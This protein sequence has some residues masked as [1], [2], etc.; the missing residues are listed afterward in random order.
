MAEWVCNLICDAM[1]N[2]SSFIY[3][4]IYQFI[5]LFVIQAHGT[6]EEKVTKLLIILPRRGP[7]AFTQFRN[8]LR[9]D[10]DWLAESLDNALQTQTKKQADEQTHRNLVKV[11]NRQLVPLVLSGNFKYADDRDPMSQTITKVGYL[12]TMLEQKVYKALNYPQTPRKTMS[13]EKMIETKLN[14]DRSVETLTS[15]I[16]E[17]KKKLKAEEKSKREVENLK[18]TVETMKKKEKNQQK[19]TKKYISDNSALKKR[20]E[21]LLKEKEGLDIENQRLKS[22][23][24]TLKSGCEIQEMF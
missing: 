3:L 12:T 11:I 8:L 21:K 13:I 14:E 23:L 10:Y 16:L 20:Y 22:E 19:M 5:Y 1:L 9:S 17:L 4:F 15:E 7:N 6:R 18:L 2:L 24:E